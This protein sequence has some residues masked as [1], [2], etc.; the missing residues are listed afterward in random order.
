[1]HEDI[2]FLLIRNCISFSP[3]PEGMICRP[4]HETNDE[5]ETCLPADNPKF[6]TGTGSLSAIAVSRS[7]GRPAPQHG[8]DT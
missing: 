7:S 8:R 2:N 5:F 3:T 6:I 1:M 4:S